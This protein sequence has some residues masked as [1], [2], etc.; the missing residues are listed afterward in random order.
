MFT[1]V[2]TGR[3]LRGAAR[4]VQMPR[5]WTA[6]QAQMCERWSG[7][8]R[9]QRCSGP[10]WQ[11]RVSVQRCPHVAVSGG[12]AGCADMTLPFQCTSGGSTDDC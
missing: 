5:S 4:W 7:L 2:V 8:A 6:W 3:L 9:V 11:V 12:A 1:S 10:A